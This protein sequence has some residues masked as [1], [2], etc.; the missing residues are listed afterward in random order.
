MGRKTNKLAWY[1]EP[2]I[3]DQLEKTLDYKFL[4][5]LVVCES[6]SNIS[7]RLKKIGTTK[8]YSDLFVDQ[9]RPLLYAPDRHLAKQLKKSF[10]PIIGDED[11]RPKTAASYGE[12]YIIPFRKTKQV[13]PRSKSAPEIRPVESETWTMVTPVPHF[14]CP[15]YH[16]RRYNPSPIVTEEDIMALERRRRDIYFELQMAE[17]KR[18]RDLQ[19]RLNRILPEYEGRV[20]SSEQYLPR[21][22]SVPSV[23]TAEI[24][25]EVPRGSSVFERLSTPRRR[26]PSQSPCHAAACDAYKQGI[27]TKEGLGKP[28]VTRWGRKMEKKQQKE[29]AD[30]LEEDSPFLFVRLY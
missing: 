22:S 15:C 11:R 20:V 4:E 10:H 19:W 9:L 8:S 24:T 17:E 5:L 21:P 2:D 13:P 28:R 16:Q 25:R 7:D 18:K 30:E 14:R 12:D 27:T 3:V 1:K 6:G 26:L 23:P 29:T